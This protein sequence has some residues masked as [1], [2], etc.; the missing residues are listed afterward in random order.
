MSAKLTDKQQL[1]LDPVRLRKEYQ[2]EPQ[3]KDKLFAEV[4]AYFDRTFHRT[5]I[6]GETIK[7]QYHSREYRVRLSTEKE[8]NVTTEGF[9]RKVAI[10]YLCLDFVCPNWNGSNQRLFNRLEREVQLPWLRVDNSGL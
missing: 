2:I 5:R 1:G 9:P 4:R 7:F 8:A 3:Y 10:G 6:E